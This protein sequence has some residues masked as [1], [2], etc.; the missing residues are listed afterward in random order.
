[1]TPHSA[2]HIYCLTRKQ[3]IWKDALRRVQVSDMDKGERG[4]RLEGRYVVFMQGLPEANFYQ[5][6][7]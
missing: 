2:R 7:L 3:I 5:A 6:E 1:M 4:D